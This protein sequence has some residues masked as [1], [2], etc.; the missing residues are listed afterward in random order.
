MSDKVIRGLLKAV[1]IHVFLHKFYHPGRRGEEIGGNG[2][3]ISRG[4]GICMVRGS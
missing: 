2:E 4:E 1:V 3:E